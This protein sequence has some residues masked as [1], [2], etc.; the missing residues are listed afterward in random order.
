MRTSLY[1]HFNNVG[2]LLYVGVSLSALQRLGQHAENSEWFNSIDRV[3][4]EHFDSREEALAAERSAII[5]DRPMHN[6][7]HKKAAAEAQRKADDALMATTQAK[8]DLTARIVCFNPVYS[9][10]GAANALD[11][12]SRLVRQWVREG[13]IGYF[14]MPTTTGKQVPY[15]SGWQLIEHIESMVAAS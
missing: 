6:I 7:H 10:H 1:R 11:V 9:L 13:K 3:T 4:I 12:S 15:I 5:Q 2:E 8:K 14:T